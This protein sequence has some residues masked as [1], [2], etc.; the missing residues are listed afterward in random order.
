MVSLLEGHIWSFI[1]D[2]KEG[3]Q[4]LPS[5]FAFLYCSEFRKTLTYLMYVFES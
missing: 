5:K 4:V 2:I 1:Y 3:R